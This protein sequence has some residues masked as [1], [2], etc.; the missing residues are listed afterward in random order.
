MSGEAGTEGDVQVA[1]PSLATVARGV[2]WKVG[3][4]GIGQLTTLGS[5]LVLAAFLPPEAFGIVAVGMVIITVTTLLME[6]GTGGAIIVAKGLTASDLRGSIA[7]N[8]VIGLSFTVAVALLADPLVRTFAEGADPA[9]LQVMMASVAIGSLGIVPLALLD[10]TFRFK[11]RA[12]LSV[13]AAVVSSLLAIA[14]AVAGGGVWALVVKHVANQGL[15]TVLAWVAI[16]DVWP[17][18]GRLPGEARRM[19]RTGA[20]WFLL[21]AAANFVAFSL[22]SLVVGRVAGVRDLG[23]YSVAF[24]LAFAPLRQVSWEVGAALLPSFAAT[25]DAAQVRRRVVKSV[26]LMAL[27]LTPFVPPAIVL[28]PEVIPALLGERWSGMVVPFQIMFAVGVAHG[29]LNVLAEAL[30]GTGHAAFRGK[31]D[32]TWALATVGAVAALTVVAGIEG[33]ALAHLAMF[34]VLAGVYV[35]LGARRMGISPWTIG[36]ALAGVALGL[37]GQVAVTA[38]ILLGA[39]IAGAPPLAA[40]FGA[41][42]AGLAAGAGLLVWRQR[43]LLEEA[44]DVVVSAVRGRVG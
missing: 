5:F 30:A 19:R 28:A 33:A 43:E 38:A 14:V 25:P 40:A 1:P 10:K 7:R 17:R 41:A 44:A 13:V 36:H 26:R 31:V 8:F 27:L 15:L 3:G 37:A 23:L 12:Q 42:L 34:F 24:A 32:I 4:R 21:M 18:G 22:D 35:A 9:V 29:V 2:S 39:Q 16:R 6:S 20:T 11:R